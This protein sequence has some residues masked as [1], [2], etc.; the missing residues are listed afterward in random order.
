M[1]TQAEKS[2][3]LRVGGTT[4]HFIEEVEFEKDLER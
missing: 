3:Y 1:Y 2:L 4:E